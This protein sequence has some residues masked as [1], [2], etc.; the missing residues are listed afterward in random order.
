VLPKIEQVRK[1]IED[2]KLPILV[3]V[4]GGVKSDNIDRVFRAGAEV[5]V[6]GSGIFRTPNYAETIRHMR[7]AVEGK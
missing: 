2:R 4:D 7:K 5:I 3:E 6:S 1:T